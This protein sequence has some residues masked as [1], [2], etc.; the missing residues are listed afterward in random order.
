MQA[1]TLYSPVATQYCRY[2]SGSI[3]VH[4]LM[5]GPRQCQV[6]A[7]TVPDGCQVNS[8]VNGADVGGDAPFHTHSTERLLQPEIPFPWITSY[9]R[10]KGDS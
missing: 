9:L 7:A 6:N 4:L 2:S 5:P 3:G 10:V 8:G 1:L